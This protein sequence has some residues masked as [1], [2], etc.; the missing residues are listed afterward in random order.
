MRDAWGC[1]KR[2][3]MNE[4]TLAYQ[5]DKE[6]VLYWN[7][8]IRFITPSVI[9]F[10][11]EYMYYKNLQ[12]AP[13]ISFEDLDPRFREAVKRYESFRAEGARMKHG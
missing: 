1:E 9:G 7:C 12:S 5:S 13:P 3:L 11:D 10:L 6:R 4:P 2:T 8:P